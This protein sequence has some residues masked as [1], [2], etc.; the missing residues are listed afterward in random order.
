[1]GALSTT[2]AP[3]ATARLVVALN[4]RG[5]A[6]I[7]RR[8]AVTIAVRVSVRAGSGP[9]VVRKTNV[10]VQLRRSRL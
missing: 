8:R 5:A 6:L 10:R 1:V 3:G 4:R 9:A 2:I 7:R